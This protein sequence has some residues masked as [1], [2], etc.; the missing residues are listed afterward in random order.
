MTHWFVVYLR[1]TLYFKVKS[2]LRPTF[3]RYWNKAVSRDSVVGTATGYGLDDRG[4]EVPSPGRV[5]NFHF[6][7]LSI[8]ALGSTQPPIQWVPGALSRG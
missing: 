7:M 3:S 1:I 4:V 6:S 8:P 5:K 2:M